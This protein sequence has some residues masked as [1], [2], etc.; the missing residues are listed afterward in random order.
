MDTL[1]EIAA[2]FRIGS[3]VAA[4]RQLKGAEV[5]AV[6][7]GNG[8]FVVKTEQS[9]PS[10]RLDAMRMTGRVESAALAAGLE[11][12]LPV[13][14]PSG[15][16]TAGYWARFGDQWFRVSELLTGV[17][18]R[19]PF[20]IRTA[21]WLGVTVARL[22]RLGLPGD[23]RD[24]PSRPL[25]PAHDWAPWLDDA[26]RA[27]L[28]CAPV[29]RAAVPVI[30]EATALVQAALVGPVEARLMHRDL[31]GRN[32]LRT[33][34]GL[35][36]LDFDYAG[37]E[38]P[39]WEAVAVAVRSAQAADLAEPS[40]PSLRAL[41]AGYA[42]ADGP[43]GSADHSAFAGLV[44]SQVAMAAYSLWVAAGHRGG[45]AVRRAAADRDAVHLAGAL[46]HTM[47]SLDRWV[48]LL[49]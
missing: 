35:R 17:H 41:L 6:S 11:I 39:W 3:L 40:E 32:I 48:D 36:L 45:D 44:W 27:G 8:S 47:S 28:A 24:D 22:A 7:A 21:T 23:V 18:P 26:A 25:Y 1:G 5:V 29:L 49:R 30:A 2:A 13:E 37:P 43:I 19:P 31:S 33:S 10:W 46:T 16:E 42:E 12:A 15:H 4:P 14:P 38:V 9:P 20:D 34:A